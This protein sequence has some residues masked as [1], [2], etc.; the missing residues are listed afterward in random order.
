MANLSKFH[1]VFSSSTLI[2]LDKDAFEGHLC[3]TINNLVKQDKSSLLWERGV[4]PNS[5]STSETLEYLE[6]L[7]LTK[8]AAQKLGV[9]LV[10]HGCNVF[11]PLQVVTE[12]YPQ[13]LSVHDVLQYLSCKWVVEKFRVACP[14]HSHN[15][16]LGSIKTHTE[17]FNSGFI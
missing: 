8:L 14:W 9:S 6:Y 3:Q 1:G 4:H 5:S 11:W 2:R 15:V 10:C 17:W 16:A 13:V 7:R 12:S